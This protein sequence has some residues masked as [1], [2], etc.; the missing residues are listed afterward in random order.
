MDVY[1]AAGLA[2]IYSFAKVV[3]TGKKMKAVTAGLGKFITP[4]EFSSSGLLVFP[5][6]RNIRKP[7]MK[8]NTVCP[9]VLQKF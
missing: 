4:K 1:R 3:L 5:S 7:S 6:G 9:T 2:L 8:Y